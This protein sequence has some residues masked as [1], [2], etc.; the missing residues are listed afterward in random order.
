MF[1]GFISALT[2][3]PFGELEK[4]GG[5]PSVT[6]APAITIL[7]TVLLFY[8]DKNSSE[9]SLKKQT[10]RKNIPITSCVPKD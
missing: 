1:Y 7:V 6:F 10:G 3:Q 4:P 9:M 2:L 5:Y 8:Q